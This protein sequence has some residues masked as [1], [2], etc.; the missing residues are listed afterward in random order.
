MNLDDAPERVRW[1]IFVML[2]GLALFLLILDSTGNLDTA[3][4]FLQDPFGRVMEWTSRRAD[5][6]AETVTGY[7]SIQDAQNEIDRLNTQLE[8]LSRENEELREIQ[9]QYQLLRD[10]FNT[11]RVTPEYRRVMANVIGHDTSPFFRSIII[12]KGR[13]HGVHVGMP[14]E[15][16]RGLVGRVYRTSEHSA[17]I[18]LISDSSSEVPARLSNTRATGRNRGGGLGGVM[19]ID[20][21]SLEARIEVGEVV[22]T[23]GIGGGYPANIPIGR[24]IDVDRREAALHQ[25]AIVQPAV[26]FDALEIVFV[27]TSFPPVDTTIFEEPAP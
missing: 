9:G 2:G 12:D 6:V 27:I 7:R 24:V 16:A 17:Q 20:W 4:D 8:A 14:V 23:S 15:S 22:M 1:F 21:V 11:A 26:D 10:L 13:T 5:P 3:F 18:I 25:R 19:A